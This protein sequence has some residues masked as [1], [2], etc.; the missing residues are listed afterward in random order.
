MTTRIDAELLI[1]GKGDPIENGSVV[2]DGGGIVYAGPTAS[3]PAADDVTEVPTV[4]PGLWECHGHFTGHLDGQPRARGQGARRRQ[5]GA[6]HGRR[7]R[8]PSTPGI[9]SVREVGGLG[10][11]IDRVVSE[12]TAARPEDLRRRVDLVDDRWPRR[13]PRSPPRLGA[14]AS[15]RRRASRVLADGVPECLKAVR[16]QLRKGRRSS[17]SAPPVVWPASSTTRST[18]SSPTRN[19][20]PSSKKRPAPSASVAAHCHGKPGI[21]AALRAGVG[22]IEHGS[23]L[24]EE[25]AELMKETGRPGADPVHHRRAARHGSRASELRLPQGR[26]A[27]ADQ[28]A[29]AMKIAVAAGV[30]I[31]TGSDIFLSSGTVRA[32]QPRGTPPGRG[33][34]DRPSRRSKRRP[35]TDRSRWE[36]RR[37]SPASCGRATT[38]TSSPWTATRSTTLGP[39]GRPLPG[40]PRLESRGTGQVAGV[41][42]PDRK[43][44]VALDRR[45]TLDRA[46]LRRATMLALTTLDVSVSKLVRMGLAT[47]QGDGSVS[48]TAKGR[49][50]CEGASSNDVRPARCGRFGV[51]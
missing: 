10:I 46:G 38:P 9:T 49:R 22:T 34:H 45:G 24:D 43:V 33:R 30:T 20:E 40:H 44:V 42:G 41:T 16:R 23:Y 2:L 14:T 47:H 29:M 18:S 39:V 35:P 7:A 1:P 32:E 51:P 6:G 19:C 5:D 15:A 36:H 27:I 4:L 25:A 50:D 26:V 31:A 3:A 17:R 8:P 12:G 48:L 21:M 11:Y 37:P 28:H 13:R